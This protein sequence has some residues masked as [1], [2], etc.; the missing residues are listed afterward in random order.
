MA[1]NDL[2]EYLTTAQA[3]KILGLTRQHLAAKAK[4]GQLGA[5]RK[6]PIWLFPREEIG[7]YAEDIRNKSPTD[8]T[9]GRKRVE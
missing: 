8:P 3:A 2:P 1:E 5:L 6:G 7:R 9:R 4:R